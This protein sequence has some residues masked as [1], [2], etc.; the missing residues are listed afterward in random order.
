METGN[1]LSE[2][3]PVSTAQWEQAIRETVTGADYAAKLIWRPEE[4]LAI[5]PYYRAED[6]AG[7][8]CLESAPGEAPYIR[9]TRAT[10]DWRIRVGIDDADPEEA[11]RAAC[12]ALPQARRRS[13]F[14]MPRLEALRT[15]HFC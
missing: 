2:F 15:S 8:Q 5:R 10:G 9:G 12:E 1:F 13:R 3:P 6:L 14:R 7:V 4:G 11:N